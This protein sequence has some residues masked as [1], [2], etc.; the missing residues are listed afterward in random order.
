VWVGSTHSLTVRPDVRGRRCANGRKANYCRLTD[1]AMSMSP[2][3]D[4]PPA[5]IT[6]RT[7]VALWKL[8][9][10]RCRV[11]RLYK[12]DQRHSNGAVRKRLT[13]AHSPISR[14]PLLDF[15]RIMTVLSLVVVNFGV[16]FHVRSEY[17]RTQFPD[18]L[19]RMLRRQEEAVFVGLY[20]N[21]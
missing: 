12:V 3:A 19:T 17:R 1:A 20:G 15:W 2:M 21:A 5:A 18:Y 9:L 6:A 7:T 10:A 8:P 16:P 4:Q 11:K 14:R 13:C